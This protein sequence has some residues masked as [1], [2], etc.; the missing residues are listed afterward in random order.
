MKGRRLG[1]EVIKPV[2]MVLAV[3]VAVVSF[4]MGS[5]SL[6]VLLAASALLTIA[7]VQIGIRKNLTAPIGEITS[8]IKSGECAPPIGIE[9]IDNL[10]DVM[11]DALATL[12]LKKQQMEILHNIAVSLNE[13]MTFDEIMDTIL[14]KSRVL[15]DADLSAFAM[16]DDAGRFRT[17]KVYGLD[18][19]GVFRKIGRLPE[20]KGIL[21][22]MRLSLVPVRINNVEDHPAFSGYFPDGHP[23]IRNFIG[24]PVFSSTGRPLGAL[25]FANKRNG[26][27][28]EEDERLLMAI[29]SDAAVAIQRV[30]EIEETERFKKI[31]ENAFDIIIITDREGRIR[32]VNRAFQQLTGYS[33]EDV[34]GR[35]SAVLKSGLHDEDFYRKLWLTITSGMTWR[36]ELINRKKNGEIYIASA[37]IYPLFSDKGE[38]THFVSIQ[39]DITE[40]KKLYEQLLRAQKMEAIGTLAGGIAH[41]FNNILSAILGYAE[42]L[43][44]ELGDNH[45]LSKAVNIIEGSARRGSDLANQILN[46]TRKEKMELR[47]VNINRIVREVIE[48]LK[49]SIPKDIEIRVLLQDELPLTKADPTQM[50]QMIMNL[51]INARDAMPGGGVLSIST[52]KVGRENGAAND[53]SSDNGYIRISIS[54]TGMGIAKDLQSKI[55]DP[56]FTTKDRGRGTGLGLYIVHSI[57]TNHGGYINLYSEPGKGT[58]FNIYLPVY[59]GKEDLDEEH[60]SL[61]SLRGSGLIL[62]IDD[63]KEIQELARDILCPLG[64]DVI[65]ASNGSEGLKLFRERKDEISLV[66]LDMI[67]PKMSGAEVFQRL[68]NI[69]DNVK[70]LLCSGYSHEGLAGIK[71]LLRSGVMGFV[72]KPFTRK[73]LARKIKDLLAGTGPADLDAG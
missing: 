16:Y 43:K 19:D 66:V 45:R 18:S 32:Y 46:I 10:V 27:F 40:E 60:Y 52:S 51:A 67:M 26:D 36:G 4:W 37:V 58:R 69:D 73:G 34:L 70:V 29:A 1:R 56:F 3:F 2:V 31:I 38:I 23:M 24:Y 14:E 48:I 50:Q 8:R 68:K 35:T 9:E 28:T 13:D 5:V 12:E 54:D 30:Q 33:R 62:V 42:I 20:G 11:N 65:T 64:Y 72:Q 53:I 61:D 71:E 47:V 39:R 7:A 21:E 22:L 15:I 55:F 41:D 59:H 6:L 44:D 49:R 17:L 25:Y 57:V 63:E